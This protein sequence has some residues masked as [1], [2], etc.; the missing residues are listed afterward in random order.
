M[1]G[2]GGAPSSSYGALNLKV[3]TPTRSRCQE[4][5][6]CSPSIEETTYDRPAVV[7]QFGRAFTMETVAPDG[8]LAP[9]SSIMTSS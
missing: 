1:A 2:D 5:R 7:V 3:T 4:T 8:A 9:K 6:F